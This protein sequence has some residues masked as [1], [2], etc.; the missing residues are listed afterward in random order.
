METDIQEA[1][2]VLNKMGPKRC[3]PNHFMINGKN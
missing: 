3:I 1:Q 2:R